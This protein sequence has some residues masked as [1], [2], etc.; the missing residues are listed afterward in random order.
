M[1]VRFVC[2]IIIFW[3]ACALFTGCG[4]EDATDTEEEPT[5][6]T[7]EEPAEHEETMPEKGPPGSHLVVTP[8][9]GGIISSSQEFTLI[10]DNAATEV[11]VNGKSATDIKAGKVWAVTLALEPGTGRAFL[12]EWTR[13]DG[14]TFD[15]AIGPY[16]VVAP[17]DGIK[18]R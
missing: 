18:R 17:E 3:S 1:Q 8:P 6:L 11:A 9:P 12:V 13:I 4:G 14:C 5:E 16:T 15:Q 7:E 2:F 10:F